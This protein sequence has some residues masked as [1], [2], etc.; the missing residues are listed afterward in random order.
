ML[1]GNKAVLKALASLKEGSF[2][3]VAF[4]NGSCWKQFAQISP[5]AKAEF[6]VTKSLNSLTSIFKP[7]F[8]AIFFTLSMITACGPGFT[9]TITGLFISTFLSSL[10]SPPQPAATRANIVSTPTR[11]YF[12][13]LCIFIYLPKQSS[14]LLE[15]IHRYY[16][17]SVGYSQER[18]MYTILHFYILKRLPQ[19]VVIAF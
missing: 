14:E 10:A 4:R 12:K 18:I 1:I 2:F 11:A 3:I 7:F 16:I 17:L 9:P 8:S 5:A 6:G 15:Y 19:V 13:N